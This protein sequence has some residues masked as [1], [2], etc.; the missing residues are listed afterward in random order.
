M[1]RY[2]AE[3]TVGWD[4]HAFERLILAG[5]IAVATP[6]IRL[7]AREQEGRVCFAFM[8]TLLWKAAAAL[9][10]PELPSR[11]ELAPIVLDTLTAGAGEL[12][13]VLPL[14]SL[15]DCNLDD[16]QLHH[17]FDWLATV[18]RK[19]PPIYSEIFVTL[20]RLTLAHCR[21]M[22][23]DGALNEALRVWMPDF[24]IDR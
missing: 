18:D 17:L 6:S 5:F 11:S 19:L 16:R 7:G 14:E 13:T 10:V 4:D 2:L 23:A 15:A 24:R 9:D 21:R 3:R 1:L 20:C 12:Y 8:H 22:M